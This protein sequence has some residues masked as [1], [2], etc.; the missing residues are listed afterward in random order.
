MV[1]PK[2]ENLAKSELP[3]ANRETSRCSPFSSPPF[4]GSGN[5]ARSSLLESGLTDGDSRCLFSLNGEL[6]C[7][8][9][10]FDVRDL[11]G[12]VGV[13]EVGADMFE[14]PKSDC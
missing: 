10:K 6:E 12:V 3:I 11:L 9:S 2:Q 4:A 13:L 7:D 1:Q 14:E 8:E 5:R